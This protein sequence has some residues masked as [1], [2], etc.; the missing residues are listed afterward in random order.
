MAYKRRKQK[1]AE[2]EAVKGIIRRKSI[3]MSRVS[4]KV[5]QDQLSCSIDSGSTHSKRKLRKKS[6]SP[7][8]S[9][10][11]ECSSKNISTAEPIE[12]SFQFQKLVEPQ[13]LVTGTMTSR[14]VQTTNLSLTSP[15]RQRRFTKITVN[16]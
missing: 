11:N 15:G 14:N 12:T 4:S 3:L 7:N 5:K 16:N 10:L 13:L 1:Q 2:L 6:E 9:V 8:T